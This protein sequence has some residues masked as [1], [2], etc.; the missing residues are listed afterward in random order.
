MNTNSYSTPST[1]VE[2][3]ER[4]WLVIDG[5]G[6]VVGRL[7]SHIA[8]LL[9][10]KHKPNFTPHVDGGDFVIVLNADKVR[11]TGRKEANK[12]YFRHTGY[13]GGVK[14]ETPAKV[15]DRKPTFIIENAIKGMLPHTKLGR[16][17]IKRLKVYAGTE[18]PHAAQSP[19]TFEL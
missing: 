9:R 19:R 18:H 1:R 7:A 4:E 14:T 16:G 10:G 2:D 11:F 6:L 8:S 12:E 17:M 3:V 13:P 5:A 15:R